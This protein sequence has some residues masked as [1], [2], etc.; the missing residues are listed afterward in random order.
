M[1]ISRSHA[2]LVHL[3]GVAALTSSMLVAASPTSAH[4]LDK[5]AKGGDISVTISIQNDTDQDLKLNKKGSGV[6]R[7]AWDEAPP[8]TIEESDEGTIS[9]ESNNK[10]GVKGQVAY[11]ADGSK[12][13]IQIFF[14]NPVK[15]EPTFGCNESGALVCEIEAND[16]DPDAIEL[17]VN[18]SDI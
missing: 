15:G 5:K 9:A 3:F 13:W 6:S 18:V 2:S 11:R 7:G 1:R 8:K 14:S 12:E 16:D 17:T 10:S 4:A